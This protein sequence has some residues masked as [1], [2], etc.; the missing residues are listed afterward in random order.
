MSPLLLAVALSV[1]SAVAYA[2]A[3]VAQA[4]LAARPHRAGGLLRPLRSG[5]WWSTVALN[6]GGALLHT[7]ALRYGSLAIV[8]PFG[9]LTLVFALPMEAAFAG[10]RV[11]PRE[12]RGAIVTVLGLTGLV[13]IT[14]TDAPTHA[15]TDPQ[16]LALSAVTAAVVGALARSGAGGGRGLRLAAAS[17][18]AS[19]V[20]SVLTQTILLRLAGPG[21]AGATG[22][23]VAGA[24]ALAVGVLSVTG[25]LLSQAAY[26]SGLGGPLA[27]L[28]IANPATAAAIGLLLLHQP[29]ALTVGGALVA[30]LA[31]LLTARGVVLLS[32]PAGSLRRPRGS[33]PPPAR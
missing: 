23:A 14:D 4:R 19:G 33:G 1:G 21:I 18:I 30:L 32:A 26:R 22:Y 3:A 5:P 17:G 6:T 13:L 25:L 27:T 16:I 9:A 7:V 29:L 20:A 15:L 10:R 31:A 12:W 2:S 8:Q 11:T 28:T 24:T